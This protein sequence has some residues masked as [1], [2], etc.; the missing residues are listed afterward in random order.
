M[1]SIWTE[2]DAR[3]TA[4][5]KTAFSTKG[6]TV[7]NVNKST[8]LKMPFGKGGEKVCDDTLLFPDP[9]TIFYID[10]VANQPRFRSTVFASQTGFSSLI[11]AS[12]GK[13]EAD[14]GGD[15]PVVSEPVMS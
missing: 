9:P 11:S 2:T 5:W 4:R 8:K 13:P 12:T 10:D 3:L 15:Q 14:S 7:T 1:T 6:G